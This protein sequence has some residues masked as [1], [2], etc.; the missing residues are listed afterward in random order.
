MWLFAAHP[1]SSSLLGP[2]RIPL[3]PSGG[4]HLAKADEEVFEDAGSVSCGC[5]NKVLPTGWFQI[6][7]EEFP[8]WHSGNES[9]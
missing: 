9:D 1:P 3:A 8:L 4:M 5:Y 7:T 6:E 2:D